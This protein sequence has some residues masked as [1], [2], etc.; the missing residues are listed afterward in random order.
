VPSGTTVGFRAGSDVDGDFLK[1]G[2]LDEDIPAEKAGFFGAHES[3]RA[4]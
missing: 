2:R 1:G 4:G 3:L